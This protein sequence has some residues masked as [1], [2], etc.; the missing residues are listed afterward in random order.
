MAPVKEKFKGEKVDEIWK[1]N[2]DGAHSIS[3]KGAGVVITSPR[4]QV[5]NFSFR[6]QFE[7]T[8]NVAEYEA[9]LLGLEIAKDMG[10]KMLN[11]KGD[12][13]L[14]ILQVK[15]H[16]SCKCQRLR[17]Y[18]NAVWDI[19]EF[20]DALNLTRIHRDQNSLAD[21]LIVATSTLPP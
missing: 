13:D 19:M 18:S 21:K 17:K 15:N 3:W 11:I 9:L 12:S 6:L 7:A 1:M 4:G 14:I 16:F 20:F 5:F 8:N 2:F 10:I